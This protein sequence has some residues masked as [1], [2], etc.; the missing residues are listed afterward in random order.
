MEALE[1][2]YGALALP[3]TP[4]LAL[5]R[6]CHLGSEHLLDDAPGFI[7]ARLAAE[8]DQQLQVLLDMVVDITWKKIT[9]LAGIT[10]NH[11]GHRA[12]QQA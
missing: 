12:Q 7:Q 6:G 3:S 8:S 4:S 10:S 2:S 9:T 1:L 11:N 5:R